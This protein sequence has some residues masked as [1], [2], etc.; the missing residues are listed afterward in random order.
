MEKNKRRQFL[1]NSWP[2]KLN[3]SAAVEDWDW[4]PKFDFDKSFDEYLI[5]IIADYYAEKK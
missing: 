1:I 3:Q 2:N 4:S 5:P